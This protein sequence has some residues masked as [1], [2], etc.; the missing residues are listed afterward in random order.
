MNVRV[1]FCPNEANNGTDLLWKKEDWKL[2]KSTAAV[3]SYSGYFAQG[4]I[5]LCD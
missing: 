1:E 2:M 5:L 4:N 3:G